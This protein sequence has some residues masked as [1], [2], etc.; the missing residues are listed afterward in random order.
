M[1]EAA[2]SVLTEPMDFYYLTRAVLD[3]SAAHQVL[4][5]E[6]FLSPDFCGKTELGPWHEY[7]SAIQEAAPEAE[8][9]HGIVM[10]GYV[11][12]IRH[13]GPDKA[14]KAALCAAETSGD[15]ICGFGMGGAETL[16]LQA[17][18]LYI[19]DLPREAGLRLTTHAGE[20]GGAESL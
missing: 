5:T 19:F 1:Y 7:L 15:F 4:Y 6:A 2:T 8:K 13:F 16:G 11:T 3:Q 20:W 17:N 12:C 9:A 18:Y 10:K 14:R